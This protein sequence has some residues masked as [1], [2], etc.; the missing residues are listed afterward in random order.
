M[1]YITVNKW[2]CVYLHFPFSV[3]SHY[4]KQLE[5]QV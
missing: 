1:D 5:K 2:K 4:M 3:N